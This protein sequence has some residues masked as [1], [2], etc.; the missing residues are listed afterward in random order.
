MSV[1]MKEGKWLKIFVSLASS[2]GIRYYSRPRK[3]VMEFT[4]QGWDNVKRLPAAIKD[5]SVVKRPL[6]DALLSN[7]ARHPRRVMSAEAEAEIKEL[8]RLVDFIRSF[9]RGKNRPYYW[10]GEKILKFYGIQSSKF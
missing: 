4:V 1:A 8:A 2:L 6:I 5:F 9:N 7:N 3:G 10:T